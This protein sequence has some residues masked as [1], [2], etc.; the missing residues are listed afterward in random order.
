LNDSNPTDPQPTPAQPIAAVAAVGENGG[1]TLPADLVTIAPTRRLSPRVLTLLLL[2][3]CLV[4]LV[5]LSGYAAMFGKASDTA[6]DVDVT[7][8]REPVE[9]VGGQGAI[10]TEVIV[11]H[12]RTAHELPNL[13]VDINGQYFLY[14]QSPILPGE[15]LVLPQQIFSTKSNQRW[16]PGRYA[17]TEINVTAK[18]PSGR[19]GVKV[20]RYDDTKA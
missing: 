19:R 18:L 2:M 10:L 3:T 15:R 20:I 5:A 1:A 7:V 6:L 14:R 16:V 8:A 4:P 9:A 17:I 12:N 11:I 13:T